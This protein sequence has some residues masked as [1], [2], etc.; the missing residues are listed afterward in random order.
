[1]TFEGVPCLDK[2]FFGTE[3]ILKI[4]VVRLGL[5][6]VILLLKYEGVLDFVRR[7]LVVIIR[8]G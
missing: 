5:I 6:F 3:V 8:L 1:M 7:V 2:I 4:R